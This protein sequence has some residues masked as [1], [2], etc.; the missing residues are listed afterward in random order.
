MLKN[1]ETYKG[2]VLEIE[3]LN[4]QR[5]EIEKSWV[6]VKLFCDCRYYKNQVR[7]LEKLGM[8]KIREEWS[9]YF[10]TA[11]DVYAADTTCPILNKVIKRWS[12]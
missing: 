11:V 2:V 6:V 10:E 8:T 9:G 5:N 12:L 7:V 3:K 1:L 4:K